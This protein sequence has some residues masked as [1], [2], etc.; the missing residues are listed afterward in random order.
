[1]NFLIMVGIGLGII[2]ML[3]FIL[4]MVFI[5]QLEKNIHLLNVSERFG[6]IPLVVFCCFITTP[7]WTLKRRI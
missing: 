5:H 3:L 7:Y 1:M 6:I 2:Y 4:S